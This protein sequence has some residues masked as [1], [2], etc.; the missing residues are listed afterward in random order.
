MDCGKPEERFIYLRK[1]VG[2]RGFE[3][4][5][6]WSRMA[7]SRWLRIQSVNHVFALTLT[8]E[9]EQRDRNQHLAHFSHE[10][11]CRLISHFMQAGRQEA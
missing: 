7:K 9:H 2:E 6:P 4:P 1:M 11:S 10:F 8:Y 5:T 3:P